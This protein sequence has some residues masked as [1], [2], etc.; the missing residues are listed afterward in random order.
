MKNSVREASV[1]TDFQKLSRILW[2]A[3]LLT[4]PVTSFRWFPFLGEGTFV[5]PLSLYPLALADSAFVDSVGARQNKTEL[6]R[7]VDSTWGVCAVHFCSDQP[8]G[9]DSIRFLCVD[10]S[11]QRAPSAPW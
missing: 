10:K 3:T 8:R 2:G 9:V 11:I 1:L 4:L 6:G 7:C 5:R